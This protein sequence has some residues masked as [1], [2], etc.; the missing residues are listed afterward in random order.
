MTRKAALLS[1]AFLLIIGC[2]P[3]S[4]EA[5]WSDKDC[6]KQDPAASRYCK[7]FLTNY[8]FFVTELEFKDLKVRH[9]I[10]SIDE[11]IEEFWKKRDTDPNTPE[12]EFKTLIDGRIRDV[13]NEVLSMDPDLAGTRF[14]VNGGLRGDMARI[15]LLYGMPHFK[16]KM[17]GQPIMADLSVW[18]YFDATGH[19]LFRFL[20]ISKMGQARLYD[21]YGFITIEDVAKELSHT[22][23]VSP[24]ETVRIIEYLYIHDPDQVFIAALVEFSYYSDINIGLALKA[25][26]PAAIV[27]EKNKPNFLGQPEVPSEREFIFSKNHAF[28]PANL[29][30]VK[31]QNGPSF[32]ISSSASGMDWEIVGDKAKASLELR[33]SFQHKSS[34]ALHQ[35]ES[36]ISIGTSSASVKSGADFYFEFSAD[37]LKN[38]RNSSEVPE[39]T[40]RDLL[41]GLEP[42]EYLVNIDLKNVYTK[43]YVSWRIVLQK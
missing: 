8:G 2:L 9:T 36:G 39:G 41:A 28:L 26:E 27:A 3:N 4:A 1:I 20:F 38:Y 11:F 17:S 13:K 43:K 35:F 6:T 23:F 10:K 16:R 25:P 7:D 42:G 32:I 31:G 18:Y 24:D 30:M 14:D 33:I 22:G 12:N 5:R 21:R 40:L 15:Y 37:G 34:R 19:V 29:R